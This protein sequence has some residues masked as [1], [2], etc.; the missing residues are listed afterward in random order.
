MIVSLINLI[1][2]LCRGIAKGEGFH[3]GYP[4]PYPSSP[5][6]K[7]PRVYPTPAG[8]YPHWQLL[9]LSPTLCQRQP[10]P[11]PA[12]VQAVVDGSDTEEENDHFLNAYMLGCADGRAEGRNDALRLAG[13]EGTQETA[14]AV[15]ARVLGI[16]LDEADAIRL[17]SPWV[18]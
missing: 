4:Y 5:L 9:E 13:V 1:K 14:R 12:P 2:H 18:S 11:S 10:S 6:L 17:R 7:T 3:N 16:D 8:H 15:A